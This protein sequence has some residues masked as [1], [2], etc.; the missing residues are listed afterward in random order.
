[1]VVQW[2]DKFYK[3]NRGHTYLGDPDVRPQAG[4]SR[5]RPCLRIG[6]QREVRARDVSG[7]N[8]RAAI[9][10]ISTRMVQPYVLN[11]IVPCTQPMSFLSSPAGKTVAEMLLE[12]VGT[13]S[14]SLRFRQGGAA[15]PPCVL[16]EVGGLRMGRASAANVQ[17]SLRKGLRG[18]RAKHGECAWLA[19]AFGRRRGRVARPLR[20]YCSGGLR[21]TAGASSAHSKR[22]R[23]LRR[24]VVW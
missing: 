18:R 22:G 4:V 9:Q 6:F 11:V 8:I 24:P 13:G 14:I 7:A 2:E 3:G 17:C 5:L 23:D 21:A 10:R 16:P 19:D 20:W 15:A 1:M 12:G